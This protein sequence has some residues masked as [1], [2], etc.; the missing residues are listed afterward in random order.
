M[1]HIPI[2]TLAKHREREMVIET[3][4]NNCG[5]TEGV[6]PR[7]RTARRAATTPAIRLTARFMTDNPPSRLT[8]CAIVG[9]L[10]P[11]PTNMGLRR[12]G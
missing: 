6:C 7:G 3:F 2:T 8:A 12:A 10:F 9:S 11:M 1:S 4:H 5:G